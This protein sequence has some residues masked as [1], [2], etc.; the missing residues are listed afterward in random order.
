MPESKSISTLIRQQEVVAVAIFLSVSLIVGYFTLSFLESNARESVVSNLEVAFHVTEDAYLFWLDQ[1]SQDVRRATNDWNL[2]VSAE[3]L[4]HLDRHP[5]TLRDHPE[6]FTFD[7]LA[8]GHITRSR[9]EDMQLVD[10]DGLT[11]ASQQLSM[12]GTLHPI[13]IS[14][15]Q[16]LEKAFAGNVTF[17]PTTPQYRFVNDGAVV[18]DKE[19]TSVFILSPISSFD[20]KVLTVVA[21]EFNADDDFSSIS[22]RART[23]VTMETYGVNEN[24]VMI[25]N[26]R[27]N[28]D[29]YEMGLLRSGEEAA[30]NIEVVRNPK[31]AGHE[32][33][34]PTDMIESLL[35]HGQGMSL[36]GYTDYRGVEVM[37]VWKW[38]DSMNFGLA[39]EI[40]EEEAL[41]SYYTTRQ[42]VVWTGTL[43]IGLAVTLLI[44]IAR[45]R[46]KSQ[47]AILSERQ[48]L[49]DVINVIPHMIFVRDERGRF[50]LANES[51]ARF[52]G[53]STSALEGKT[54]DEVFGDSNDKL[55][56][57]ELDFEILSGREKKLDRE[58]T[59]V[60]E[61][62]NVHYHLSTRMPV[63]FRD[64]KGELIPAVLGV[65]IDI[66]DLKNAQEAI[67]ASEANLNAILN[68]APLGVEI[69]TDQ[70]YPLRINAAMEQLLG[71]GP[72][73]Y[74]NLQFEDLVYAADLDKTRRSFR[75]ILSGLVDTQFVETRLITKSNDVVWAQVTLRLI[76]DKNNEVV[77]ILALYQDITERKKAELELQKFNSE[78]EER[79]TRRTSELQ[80]KN[81]ELDRARALADEANEAK[82]LFLA[83]MSHEL[84]TPLNAIIGLTELTLDTPLDEEQKQYLENV[85]S[86]A[87]TLL[88]IVNDILDLTKAESGKIELEVA[89]FS[90]S[91]LLK[92][93]AGMVAHASEKKSLD[94]IADVDPRIP[95]ILYGDQLRLGQVLTNLLSNAVKFTA[96]G[97]VKLE[98]SIE[99]MLDT[100]CR[101]CFKVIDTGIGIPDD[102]LKLL[103]QSFSQVDASMTR[104]F[105]GTGLGLS[106]SRQLVQLMGSD[107][108][109]ESEDGKGS[110]FAFGIDFKC[111]PESIYN[112]A[113][114][115]DLNVCLY[116]CSS[117][118]SSPLEKNLESIGVEYTSID[119]LTESC[120]GKRDRSSDVVVCILSGKED[121]ED[122]SSF[123]KA[124]EELGKGI[125]LVVPASKGQPLSH[126]SSYQKLKIKT[127]PTMNRE[128][129]IALQECHE[130][131]KLLSIP[132]TPSKVPTKADGEGVLSGLH[133]LVVEDNMLNQQVVKAL[134]EKEQAEV[135]LTGNGQEALD[136]LQ[137]SLYDVV[138]M[139]IQMPVMDGYQAVK[140]IRENASWSG[141]PV[142][143]LTA[144]ALESDIDKSIS[145]GF[146]AHLS[147][148][149][150]K[151]RLLETIREFVK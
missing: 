114:L 84:R 70:G 121:V 8:A 79:V 133:V 112:F 94:V 71:Y 130:S 105:G 110:V 132:D 90:I 38:I 33:S 23:G 135:E 86:S 93:V 95:D 16:L 136:A 50:L 25:T 145:A 107:I 103:F 97:Y 55:L 115:K 106:I 31:R 85:H 83:N 14:Y 61:H 47:M 60:D 151:Q 40:D 126:I 12:V 56:M 98:V 143:A 6:Q 125:V 134:L 41:S 109:V 35:N 148:P 52:V 59:S 10:A 111:R 42:A 39:T 66:T 99:N 122:I 104:K 116:S 68:N 80:I 124:C 9:A 67:A 150:R 74:T 100:H 46:S 129:L 81:R 34:Q 140:H 128:L 137:N 73:E 5:D 101:V 62:G 36:D 77:N 2:Q 11:I 108:L 48:T 27:F 78:L 69:R 51:Q 28:D 72:S 76:R 54:I 123:V 87:L 144:N 21:L 118:L 3:L 75:N 57:H 49:R 139:D 64:L 131:P 88:T 89:E 24:G 149:L 1:K 82:S 53:M 63:S 45:L 65:L 117:L 127:Y 13:A 32:P 119:A 142:I 4:S 43:F 37:G 91:T 102:K 15:P 19:H 17:V 138:L 30:L 7:Q 147:K 141:L 96:E 26:S 120:L 20:G 146:D 44:F 29:L 18:A 58:F 92:Q 113:T 22:Q